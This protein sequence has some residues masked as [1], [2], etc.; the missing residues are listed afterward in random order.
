M[1]SARSEGPPSSHR[2]LRGFEF[3]YV[4]LGGTQAFKPLASPNPQTGWSPLPGDPSPPVSTEGARPGVGS[5][6][7]GWAGRA[8]GSQGT[9]SRVRVVADSSRRERPQKQCGCG[10]PRWPQALSLTFAHGFSHAHHDVSSSEVTVI[11]S[12]AQG[13][14][15]SEVQSPVRGDPKPPG[16]AVPGCTPLS[17]AN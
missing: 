8:G 1:A 13:R 7:S 9:L 16:P 2:H 14:W 11:S 15:G 6:G 17:A 4:N 3:Q 12:Y 10:G 5:G